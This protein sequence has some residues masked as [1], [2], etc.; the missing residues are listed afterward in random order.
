[1]IR[2]T[3]A[4]LVATP[5]GTLRATLTAALLAGGLAGTAGAA[6]HV[7]VLV[8]TQPGK[9][10]GDSLAWSTTR[11]LLACHAV[12]LHEGNG[13]EPAFTDNKECR[14]KP[15]VDTVT[16]GY[17]GNGASTLAGPA[18]KL[19]SGG[20]GVLANRGWRQSA[21]GLSPVLLRAGTVGTQPEFEGT[22]AVGGSDELAEVT[23][24]FVFA[25]IGKDGKT[26]E[27]AEIRE[28]RRMKPDEP[29]YFDNPLAG[30]IIQV[31][32]AP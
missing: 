23:I 31:S 21:P 13:A 8:F 17:S 24:D 6:E 26:P 30:A 19:K 27:Y 10:T 25:R 14:K 22:V 32:D 16:A 4:R 7:D 29:H 5:A 11:P 28:T 18:A 2:M 1:M 20:Y 15:G 9:N 12:V 3:G